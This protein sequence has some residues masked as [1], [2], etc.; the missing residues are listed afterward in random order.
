MSKL[1]T[2]VK[3]NPEYATVLA[4]VLVAAATGPALTRHYP[5]WLWIL[6]A[7]G[8]ASTALILSCCVLEWRNWYRGKIWRAAMEHFKAAYLD[9]DTQAV[10]TGRIN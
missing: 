10:G 9:Q 1:T 6:T 4:V 5:A 2:W 8:N 7:F 3:T